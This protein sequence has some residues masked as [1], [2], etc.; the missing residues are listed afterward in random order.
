MVEGQD[1]LSRHDCE[2]SE[3]EGAPQLLTLGRRITEREG[4]GGGGGIVNEK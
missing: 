1:I 4:G 2:W 3:P